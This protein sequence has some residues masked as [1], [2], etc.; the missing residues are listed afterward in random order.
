M[1][2]SSPGWGH[3]GNTARPPIR[4]RQK[5][6]ARRSPPLR[7]NRTGVR[8]QLRQAGRSTSDGAGR[9]GFGLQAS[10]DIPCLIMEKKFFEGNTPR[11][12]GGGLPAKSASFLGRLRAA[13]WAPSRGGTGTKLWFQVS[14]I[15]L[16]KFLEK[17][18]SWEGHPGRPSEHVGRERGLLGGEGSPSAPS[19]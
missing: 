18:F 19:P 13:V 2:P 9:L 10:Q 12:A 11:A 17:K 8:G 16:F 3:L 4:R 5:K 7:G 15:L 14:N 6:S 1:I